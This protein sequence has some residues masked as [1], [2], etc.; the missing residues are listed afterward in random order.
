MSQ[1]AGVHELEIC[2]QS[3]DQQQHVNGCPIRVRGKTA[4]GQFLPIHL[5]SGDPF[6]QV[7][8]CNAARRRANISFPVEFFTTAPRPDRTGR[9]AF[10]LP[11]DSERRHRGETG[12]EPCRRSGV[13]VC[14]RPGTPSTN[15]VGKRGLQRGEPSS[16]IFIY[17]SEGHQSNDNEGS[18]RGS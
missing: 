8:L 5:P 7:H 10:V 14:C 18:A 11:I 16:E 6:R 15:I 12:R 17:G 4:P 9:R 3:R 1:Q 13:F 2:S